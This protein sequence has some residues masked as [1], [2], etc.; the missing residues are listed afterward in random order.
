MRLPLLGIVLFLTSAVHSPLRSQGGSTVELGYDDGF[1]P[2]LKLTF[3]VNGGYRYVVR[4]TPPS[5]PAQLVRVRYFLADTSKGTSFVLHVM[6][7]NYNA[8]KHEPANDLT[9]SV[10]VFRGTLGWNEVDLQKRNIVVRGDFYAGIY[11][12][13]KSKITIGAENRKPV[14]GRAYDSD[15]CEWWV[16]EDVDLYL[17]AVLEY[18]A[19]GIPP[20][21]VDPARSGVLQF[22]R[23]YPNPFNASTSV[24]FWIPASG[25][26]ALTVHD[27]SGRTLRTL[28][29]EW[30]GAGR[31]TAA[32]DGRDEKGRAL[33]SG[34]YV[35]RLV[36]EGQPVFMQKM[37]LV[38]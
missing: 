2:N 15:C 3:L 1:E 6:D 19:T 33:P 22:L 14:S 17:H 23:N 25:P 8:P 12:D 11:Y 10:N 5:V 13:L 4:F 30:K 38:R 32:W 21:P 29:R 27:G 16:R 20:D 31:G 9:D 37:V 26:A 34:V 24:R 35:C 18:G 36:C 28:F 7:D